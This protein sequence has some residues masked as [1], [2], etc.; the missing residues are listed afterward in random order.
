M[1]AVMVCRAARYGRSLQRRERPSVAPKEPR[2]VPSGNEQ[3]A[4]DKGP[5][6]VESRCT[7]RDQSRNK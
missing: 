4:A 6:N 2:T 1:G 3:R 5:D 7:S